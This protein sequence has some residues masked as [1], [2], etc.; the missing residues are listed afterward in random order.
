MVIYSPGVGGRHIFVSQRRE[1]FPDTYT[2]VIC[3][4]QLYNA[5]H[6]ELLKNS[7]FDSKSLNSLQMCCSYCTRLP[8]NVRCLLCQI[9]FIFSFFVRTC[10]DI[11]HT[12]FFPP[13]FRV[14]CAVLNF[15]LFRFPMLFF[16]F[17]FYIFPRHVWMNKVFGS[18]FSLISSGYRSCATATSSNDKPVNYEGERLCRYSCSVRL[19]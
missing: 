15:V 5:Q 12:T 19:A 6:G 8:G 7:F 14:Q 2:A 17:F 3:T 10:H 9:V 1:C 11:S 4:R 18:S 16:F 13:W